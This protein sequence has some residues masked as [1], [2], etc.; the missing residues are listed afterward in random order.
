MPTDRNPQVAVCTGIPSTTR[1]PRPWQR[2]HLH[3]PLNYLY[4]TASKVV[5]VVK[6]KKKK[7]NLPAKSADVRDVGLISGSGRSPGGG[8]GKP[9]QYSC[10]ENP[11]DRGAWR[12]YSPRGRRRVG[13]DW[14][15]QH[16]H[17]QTHVLLSWPQSAHK[18]NC[19][20]SQVAERHPTHQSQNLSQTPISLSLTVRPWGS[21]GSLCVFQASVIP[22]SAERR[23]FQGW[24][25]RTVNALCKGIPVFQSWKAVCKKIFLFC[26]VLDLMFSLLTWLTRF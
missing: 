5:L 22:V 13:H 23:S 2:A 26:F 4:A 10:P 14:V 12:G 9:L 15:T 17:V 1:C 6:K 21:C 20:L 24:R 8:H 3:F 16:P 18:C 7:A 19:P 11:L 25:D